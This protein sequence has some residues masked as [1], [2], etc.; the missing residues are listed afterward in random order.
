MS[1]AH[2]TVEQRV[3]YVF[4]RIFIFLTT[5]GIGMVMKGVKHRGHVHLP[6]RISTRAQVP[7]HENSPQELGYVTM[8]SFLSD[9]TCDVRFQLNKVEPSQQ[10]EQRA[11]RGESC[12]AV[13]GA[14]CHRT[15]IFA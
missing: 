13:V 15:C 10:L 7:T 12:C 6:L 14:F 5:P 8:A 3:V 9:S 1:R 4:L 2:D 11:S